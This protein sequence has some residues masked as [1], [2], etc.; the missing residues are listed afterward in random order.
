MH[1]LAA[2]L[3]RWT[4]PHPGWTPGASWDREVGSVA[5]QDGDGLLLIDPLAPPDSTEEAG[6]FW[7]WL[8][9][10]A[11]VRVLL[12]NRF[13]ERSAPELAERVGARVGG[14]PPPGVTAHAVDGLDGEERAFYLAEHRAL[15]FADAVLG[16]GGGRLEIAPPSWSADPERYE[17]R[18]RE[19]LRPLRDLQVEWVLP[20]HGAPVLVGGG[21]ALAAAVDR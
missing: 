15:V 2:G 4:A 10:A 14:E 7:R 11:S 20:A 6:A 18:F 21:V 9:R 3:W 8:E 13:H 1:R 17:R 12:G 5:V 16:R 19:T